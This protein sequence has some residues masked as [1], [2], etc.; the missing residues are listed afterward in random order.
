[1]SQPRA[2]S[3]APAAGAG[4][5]AVRPGRLRGRL[6][7]LI[8]WGS[9][10]A[11]SAASRAL[12][13]LA[14]VIV[15]RELG[16]GGFGDFSIFI[17]L[18][19]VFS[20][21]TRFVDITYVRYASLARDPSRAVL[22]ATLL[23]K[24]AITAVFAALAYPLARALARF[25]YD[26]DDLTGPIV[27]AIVAGLAVGLVAF[28]AST[29]L[30]E[31][32][33][34]AYSLVGSLFYVATIVALLPTWIGGMELEATTV[35]WIFLGAALAVGLPALATLVASAWPLELDRSLMS[36]VVRFATW[37]FA[38]NLVS[39]VLLRLDVIL[40]AAYVDKVEVG[41]YGAA[42]RI[43]MVIG[44]LIG[45]MSG[46]F[47]P[48]VGETRSSRA[49]LRAYLHDARF[50]VLVL[51][52]GIVLTWLAAP[53]LVR[54]LFGSEFAD[55]TSLVRIILLGTLCMAISAPLGQL[56]LGGEVPRGVVFLNLTRL[57]VILGLILL[58]APRFGATGVAWAYVGSE[59]AAVV[60]VAVAAVVIWRNTP[61]AET[62]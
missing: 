3:E 62:D 8:G 31:R 22:R 25:L 23:M 12:S 29:F 17:A 21:A 37:L 52:L 4:T 42:V 61:E 7:A 39:V 27:F 44:L 58:L 59:L 49:A 57:G 50:F 33:Y 46:F 11:G 45:A 32:R 2:G 14:S 20:M 47:L 35:Y 54:G 15:A 13:V 53:L 10:A 16:P 48:R 30:A 60:Y 19:T 56:L 26:R 34:V 28:R 36:N 40:L 55:A 43:A 41:F 24:L 18:L 5:P 51:G 38:A 1:M 9:I 6:R